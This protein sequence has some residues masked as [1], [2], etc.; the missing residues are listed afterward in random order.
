MVARAQQAAPT[1]Q[2]EI[3]EI[4]VTAQKR[5]QTADTVG[6]SITAAT[7]QTLRERGINQVTDLPQLV[8][9]F[10]VQ[11]SAFNSTSFTL[12][13]V[14]FFNSDLATPPAVTVYVDEVPL[15]YP[16]MTKLA[17]FDVDRVE[18]L[19]GPQG[20]L[21]GENATGGAVNYIAA[22]PTQTFKSGLD[23]TYGSYNR[24]QAGGFVSGPVNDEVSIRFALQGERG[25]GWQQS[26]TRPG[27]R[28]GRLD[29]LQGRATVDWRPNAQFTSRLTVTV[30]HDGS[31]SQAGQ[32]IATRLEVPPLAL[33]GLVAFPV[34][35]TPT[36]ADWAPVRS[37]TGA[38]FP[39]AS[40][41]TLYQASWRNDY[42][43]AHDIT[44]TS[45]TSYA[46]FRMA[47]GQDPS[48][49]PFQLGNT[50]DDD[51]R[52]SSFYQE[53]RVA[54]QTARLDW[55]VGGNYAQD[56]VTDKPLEFAGDDSAAHVFEFLDP[57]AYVDEALTTSEMRAKT[58]A[59][60]GRVEYELV[61]N[62]KIEGGVRLN[63][64]QRTF[65]N[66]SIALTSH[67]ASFWNIFRAA[68]G[69][70]PSPPTEIG[71]CILLNPAN[72]YR[73]VNDVHNAL[74]QGSTSWRAGLDW[75][76]EPNL[77]LY[78]NASKGFK[79]GAAPVL[80][81]S[82]TTELKPVPQ[83]SL[84]AYEA[85]AKA[86]LFDRQVELNVSVFYY[87]YRDKQLR[88]A[89]R[90]PVFGPLEALVSIPKS[91]VEGAEVQLVAHP[92]DGLTIDTSA[93][94]LQTEID[95]F[96]GFDA[97]ANFSNQAG[98]P[99]PFSPKWQS[100]TN[101]DYR[102]PISSAVAGFVGGSLNYVSETYAGVGALNLMRIDAYTL[103]GLRAG[104]ELDNGRYRLW[105][106]GKNVTNEYYWNNV[107]VFA[108][109]VSR[110][111]GEPATY[112]VSLSARF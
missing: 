70:A 85:G 49:T 5:D 57:Q 67:F 60:F 92:I 53:L 75:R 48:G 42:R 63:A 24:L 65:D 78:A 80:S 43:L 6:M 62:V 15:P 61:D 47:Y 39:Y 9:G 77:L 107:F 28:L 95:Q 55:L 89:F 71:D 86:S 1:P 37:D 76:A 69:G 98:T 66:C 41:T 34:V 110:F 18:V 88:G 26:I 10:T 79:A 45:L 32:F 21:Y 91:H 104:I 103:L 106:W 38:A 58:F 52:V 17:A 51:G 20:T 36:A 54:G 99:F 90:D 97:L 56:E 16:A 59:A 68:I 27:D 111:V 44:F 108:D 3:E 19:K 73:P 50:I 96:I 8:P 112:G 100:I 33:P 83:E 64:D 93:T 4:V 84:L 29:E 102:F 31:D 35:N 94:Y 109:A 46:Y 74:N 82:T 25:D 72:D 14:G 101:V 40:D 2:V 12:R 23:V 87:D 81:A 11:Q 30:T 7:E 22:K 13:G 105:A